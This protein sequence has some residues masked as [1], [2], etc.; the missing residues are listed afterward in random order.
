MLILYWHN[1]FAYI[2]L[3]IMLTYIFNTGLYIGLSITELVLIFSYFPYHS[4]LVFHRFGPMFHS[5]TAAYDQELRKLALDTGKELDY[6]QTGVY[7]Y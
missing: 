7:F 6:M 3:I 2:M 1:M 4:G 5:K